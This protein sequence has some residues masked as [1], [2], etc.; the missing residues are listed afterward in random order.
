DGDTALRLARL[1]RP[2]LMVLDLMLPGVDGL[3]II[4]SLRSSPALHLMSVIMLTARVEEA[5]RLVGLELGADDYVTKPFGMDELLRRLRAALRRVIPAAD[6]P[7][8]ET[9][10]F[11]ID[12]PSRRVIR[13]GE[14]VPLTPTEWQLVEVLVR[15]RGKLVPQH[16]LVQEVWGPQHEEETEDLRECIARLRQKLEPEHSRPRY[17]TTE[18]G[19]GYRFDAGV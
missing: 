2:S 4:R 6:E 12:L 15:N 3:D 18:A 16:Q 17:F 1:E 8:I 7:A 13:N 10:D 9:G 14:E 11:T 5:D 19:L